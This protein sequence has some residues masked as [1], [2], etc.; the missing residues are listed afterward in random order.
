MSTFFPSFR[1]ILGSIFEENAERRAH[2]STMYT[3]MKAKKKEG[4]NVV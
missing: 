1:Y 2:E 4:G 3:T